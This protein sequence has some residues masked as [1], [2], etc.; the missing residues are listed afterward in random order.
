M[1]HLLSQRPSLIRMAQNLSALDILVEMQ[2][3]LDLALT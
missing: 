3:A 2:P 1:I